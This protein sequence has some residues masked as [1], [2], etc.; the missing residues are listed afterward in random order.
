MVGIIS[1]G[2]GYVVSHNPP[3]SLVA[4]H[5]CL[6]PVHAVDPVGHLHGLGMLCSQQSDCSDQSQGLV[7]GSNPSTLTRV[8]ATVDQNIAGLVSLG[9]DWVAY[10]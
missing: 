9:I 1:N 4:S 6:F 5:A 7:G 8:T 3:V 2:I 10:E